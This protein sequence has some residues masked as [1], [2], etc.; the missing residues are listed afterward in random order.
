MV[1]LKL[2]M[3]SP[4]YRAIVQKHLGA[5]TEEVVQKLTLP[6]LAE[7]GLTATEAAQLVPAELP[8]VA[9]PSAPPARLSYDPTTRQWGCPRCRAFA[10]RDRRAVTTHFRFCSGTTST[11]VPA[12]SYRALDEAAQRGQQLV[13]K[14]LTTST[15]KIKKK[16]KKKS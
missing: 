9:M 15:K 5:L 8:H 11:N 7:L 2:L 3:Q 16:P 6:L 12:K 14:A 1:N 13:D 10:R 4:E